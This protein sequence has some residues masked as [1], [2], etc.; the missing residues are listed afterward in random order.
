MASEGTAKDKVREKLISVF[1]NDEESLIRV[2]FY[3]DEEDRTYKDDHSNSPP[4][5]RTLIS[6]LH[7]NSVFKKYADRLAEDTRRAEKDEAFRA[8]MNTVYSQMMKT[9]EEPLQEEEFQEFSLARM[10]DADIAS[11]SGFMGLAKAW[12]LI[13][14]SSRGEI[15]ALIPRIITNRQVVS[16]VDEV[17][18]LVNRTGG[19]IVMVAL[20]AISL[21]Y[22][23]I[24]NLRR[25]YRGEISGR[26]CAKNIV[27]A[28]V[29]IGAGAAG[30]FAGAAVG[31]L[32]GPLGALAGGVLGGI[33]SS[34]TANF[35]CDRLTQYL[36]GIP[37]D[38]A[39]ENAYNFIGVKMTASN[40]EINAAFRKLCLQHHPDKGGKSEDF[41]TVQI[42]MGVIK[43]SRGEML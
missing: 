17:V 25:W 31:S 19:N 34:Q 24:K 26:R 1:E 43:M 35:L 41:I 20:A 12:S 29:S 39:L 38:E 6:T 23:A 8:T 15:L 32:A 10:A 28:S 11:T 21:T 5:W 18:S 42:N 14:H 16:A 27:D 3:L 37:K 36:F 33:L 40:N 4:A 22:E 2:L 13:P 30:G 7:V 9:S